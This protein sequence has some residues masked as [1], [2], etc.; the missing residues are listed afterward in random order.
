MKAQGI[1][2][3]T[4]G[5]GFSKTAKPNDG[6]TD[7]AALGTLQSCA[8]ANSTFFYPY[9]AA[10][11][12]TSFQNIGNAIIAGNTSTTTPTPGALTQ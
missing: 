6:S 5:F 2:V 10:A 8:S 3:Y 4:V 12:Q 9:D 11:L 7:G 1:T